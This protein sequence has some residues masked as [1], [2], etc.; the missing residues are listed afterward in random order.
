MFGKFRDWAGV[1]EIINPVSGD[2]ELFGNGNLLSDIIHCFWCLSV[3]VG[4]IVCAIAVILSIIQWQEFI[5]YALATS[6][7]AIM[8]ETKVFKEV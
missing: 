2:R 4:G 5:F 1:V 8:F 3:W 6:A 7:I